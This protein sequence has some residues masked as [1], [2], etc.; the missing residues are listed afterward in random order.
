MRAL[1]AEPIDRE[2]YAPF[3][4]LVAPRDSAPRAA[5]HGRAEAWDDLAELA[6]LRPLAKPS[7]SL[8]RCAPERSV[9]LEVRWLER[10]PRS[11]QMFVPMRAGRYLV[12][13][14]LGGDAPE[15]ASLRAFVVEGSRAIT[16]RP[17]VSHHPLIALDG[18]LDFVNFVFADGTA[19]DCHEIA[20][21][22]ACARVR[23]PPG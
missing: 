9:E 7:V 15:L 11:T 21:D 1:D 3:G 2:T 8:F 17:G 4:D 12:V 23:I 10:H 13:V 14:A 22:P 18:T 16:Y 6:N 20:F 19:D 5:N